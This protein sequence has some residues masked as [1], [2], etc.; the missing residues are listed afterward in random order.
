MPFHSRFIR[1]SKKPS[2]SLADHK[3][4]PITPAPQSPPASPPRAT[5]SHSG[6]IK[7]V[8]RAPTFRNSK[9][10]KPE[11]PTNEEIL[12][13]VK[14]LALF[15]KLR[16]DISTTAGLFGHDPPPEPTQDDIDR[17]Q[18]K[19]WQVYVT[20]AVERFTIWWEKA[21][22]RT[23][24]GFVVQELNA[25][26]YEP[27]FRAMLSAQKKMLEEHGDFP[28]P[29]MNLTIGVDTLPP[30]DVIMVWHAYAMN[31]I[32]F[33][34]D[35]TRMGKL[36][37]WATGLPI[38]AVSKGFDES[39]LC[40]TMTEQA[41]VNWIKTTGLPVDNLDMPETKPVLC[42]LCNATTE[43]PWTVPGTYQ[44]PAA[45]FGQSTSV[46]WSDH[47]F[48][49]RCSNKG[50][51]HNIT[52]DTISSARFL[53]ACRRAKEEGEY[54]LPVSIFDR[55]GKINEG[56]GNRYTGDPYFPHL[57]F[58]RLLRMLEKGLPRDAGIADIWEF[59][60]KHAKKTGI[61]R[62][63]LDELWAIKRMMTH[64]HQN[65][66]PFGVE[67]VG[68]V[69]RQSL[70]NFQIACLKWDGQDSDDCLF[71]AQNK[72]RRMLQ[73]RSNPNNRFAIVPTLDADLVWC[74][75]LLS[76]Q[77]Y[78][79]VTMNNAQCFV[80]HGRR[81]CEW[82]LADGFKRTYQAMHSVTG[83]LYTKCGCWFCEGIR[84]TDL[85]LFSAKFKRKAAYYELQPKPLDPRTH[86]SAY[87]G[88]YSGL[89]TKAESSRRIQA[90][91]RRHESAM[92][93]RRKFV[94]D[95][96][97]QPRPA[98]VSQALGSLG[99]SVCRKNYAINPCKLVVWTAKGDRGAEL[100]DW[101]D[102]DLEFWGNDAV[103]G[104]FADGS[105]DGAACGADGGS[106]AGG[107][108]SP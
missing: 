77:R 100:P 76:P 58:D 28:L 67:L 52:Y 72:Y 12:Q 45:L 43:T 10:K 71:T 36:D 73:L 17:V 107:A 102:V 29:G 90:L 101:D 34:E 62:P 83:R 55:Q 27:R 48:S 81:R 104:D 9:D 68:T 92:E 37:F 46:G 23:L 24:N 60:L 74:T 59:V 42:P 7:P 79:L 66:G 89:L 15:D 19:R 86:I 14:L 87:T 65:P 4:I 82:L 53:A 57:L 32:C 75:N 3:R 31:A 99:M 2:M 30:L 11:L 91:Q 25:T 41:E 39:D 97:E 78:W 80:D 94:T 1:L 21:I 20:R 6:T 98:D 84:A 50:C 38:D 69:V 88:V 93:I 5:R 8:A 22:P 35:C 61:T 56:I 16:F 18:E 51:Q 108:S 63:S 105:S 96:A 44:E 26:N 54:L 64:F 49:L 13:H 47:G 33:L 106:C 85:S 70:F 40:Y 95:P 103:G